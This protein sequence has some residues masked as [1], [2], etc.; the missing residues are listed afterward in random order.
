MCRSLRHQW[1]NVSTRDAISPARPRRSLRQKLNKLRSE[2][3]EIM[4]EGVD[5]LTEKELR[6]DLRARGLPT[7]HQGAGQMRETLHN[8]LALS[9]KK[10][11][12]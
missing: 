11:I 1:C 2:D 4:W 10:E 7:I 9:Q 6:Q 3:K 8:W 5:T 12:P